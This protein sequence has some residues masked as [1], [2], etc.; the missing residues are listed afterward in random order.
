[1]AFDTE[2]IKMTSILFMVIT[3]FVVVLYWFINFVEADD[4]KPMRKRINSLA[5]LLIHIPYAAAW[6]YFMFYLHCAPGVETL[7][8]KA[9]HKYDIV[10]KTDGTYIYSET[11]NG[12]LKLT[13]VLQKPEDYV[14]IIDEFDAEPKNG[15]IYTNF[16]KYKY[17]IERKPIVITTPGPT[18]VEKEEEVHF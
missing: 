3:T 9:T 4:D 16:I 8:V 5:T 10:N 17:R 18:V 15:M 13:Y 7:F 14:Y 1:M 12:Q 2:T 11:N 6:F